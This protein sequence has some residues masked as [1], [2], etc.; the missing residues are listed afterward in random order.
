MNILHVDDSP[1]ICQL[2]ADM[3]SSG[4]NSVTS[5]N[6]GKEGLKLALKNTYDLILLDVCMP[7]YSGMEFIHDLKAK[8]PSELKKI[9]IVSVL[10]LR[11]SHKNELLKLGIHSVE[12]KPSTI[13]KLET[14][15]K[16]LQLR[17]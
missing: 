2:Y 3:L 10:E 13:Q 15:K 11:E 1:E 5:I 17:E 7:K 16:D 14:I 8:R 6:D 9:I 4:N 12:E